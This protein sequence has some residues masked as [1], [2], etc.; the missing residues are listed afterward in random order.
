[1]Q[2]LIVEDD[3]DSADFLQKTLTSEKYNVQI[4]YSYAQAEE[5]IAGSAVFSIILL[6]LN[7]GDGNGYDLLREIRALDM[8]TSVIMLTSE[9]DVY[10]KAGA[11][12]A[13]ADDYLCK[14]YSNIELL[15][16]I[17]AI[18]RRESTTKTSII[19]IGRLSLN[20]AAHEISLD[21]EVLTLTVTEYEL[22]ELFMQNKNVVLTRYQLNEHI[23]KDFASVG[24]SNIIDAHIKN[25]RKKLNGYDIIKTVRGV[26]YTLKI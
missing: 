16:R 25:L 19:T 21:N 22:L 14:P 13:G 10:A 4:A 6:D 23:M 11:L 1:M 17:R 7:L 26:G 24:N 5:I 2:I 3:K 18:S 20:A 15:A 12:D 9:N 8:Q